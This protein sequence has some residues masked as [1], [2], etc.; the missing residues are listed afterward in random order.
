MFLIKLIGFVL[1]GTIFFIIVGLVVVV[2]GAMASALM[3]A[4]ME[5]GTKFSEALTDASIDVSHTYASSFEGV[6]VKGVL[7]QDAKELE[8]LGRKTIASMKKKAAPVINDPGL[9]KRLKEAKELLL[10]H[11]IQ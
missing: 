7:K 2:G 3:D 8:Q 9:Q 1:K 11:N 4:E 6:D 5:D 10:K